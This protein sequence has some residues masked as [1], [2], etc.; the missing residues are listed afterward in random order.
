MKKHLLLFVLTL[1]GAVQAVYAQEPYAVLSDDNT[2]VTFYYDDQKEV[3]GGMDIGGNSSYGSATTA[4]IDASFA[5]YRPTSTAHWFERCSSLTSI[6]GMENLKTDNVTDMSN[7]FTG[8]SGLLSLDVS[9]FNTNKVTSMYGMFYGCRSLTSLDLSGFHTDN[10]TNMYQ[11]FW[12]CSS[13]TSLDV[14]GFNTNKVTSMYGMFCRCSGLS[15]LEVSHFNTDNVTNMSSMFSGCSGL[16]S[17]DVTSF[18]TD[19]V[20]GMS[21]M[22]SDCSGL[23]SLDV[24][25]LNTT[26]V[27][28][29]GYMFNRCLGLTSLDVSH[30]NTANVMDMKGMFS[31]C[32]GLTNLDVS[33]FNTSNVTDMQYMF[34]G[35]S[36]LTSLD[37]TNFNTDNVTNMKYMFLG[38]S[39]LTSL[40]IRSF[41]TANVT[42]MGWMFNSCNNLASIYVGQ[43]WSTAKITGDNYSGTSMFAGDSNL[44]GGAGTTYDPNND[45]YTYAHVD[46]GPDNPGYFT[47]FSSYGITVAGVQVTNVNASAITGDNITGTV[48]FDPSSQILTL[49]GAT[50]NGCIYSYGDLTIDLKGENTITATDTCTIKNTEPTAMH[51]LTFKSTDGTGI[52]TLIPNSYSLYQGFNEP[53]FE[54]YLEVVLGD[55]SGGGTVVIQSIERYDLWIGG[56]QVTERN[57]TDILGDGS[58]DQGKA[59]SFQYV[60]SLNKLFITNT[61]ANLKVETKNPGGLIVYLAPRSANAVSNIVYTGEQQA[62]PLT[63]TTDGNYP[64]AITLSSTSSN[65]YVIMGFSDLVLEQNLV[66]MEPYDN[67]SS[68]T[69]GV[70]LT[71][72]TKDKV[73]VP[74]GSQ[75]VAEGGDSDINKVVD[76]IL[77][78]FGDTEEPDGDGFDDGGFIVINTVTD[79]HQA[80]EAI[81]DYTPGTDDFMEH[82]KGM[83][84]MVPAGNGKIK[85]DVQTMDGHILKVKVGDAYPASFEKTERG[86]VEIPYNIG[87][88]TYVYLYNGGPAAASARGK[89]ISKGGKKKVTH[90][91]VYKTGVSTTKVNS[92]NPVGEASGGAYIGDTSDLEGQEV[93]SD[94]DNIAAMGD[95]DGDG[96]QT[97]ADIVEM[98]KAIMGKHSGVY[99]DTNADINDDGEINI[100][101]IILIVNKIKVE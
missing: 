2:V 70:P 55:I 30:F 95:V 75:I 62:G 27:T 39:S 71:P 20:T 58:A 21:S 79:D 101:D 83:T 42:D 49:N 69:I 60:P 38:C 4:V 18:K 8:C 96:Q 59:A 77:Y 46:G 64:G 86:E 12:L 63:I 3:R 65:D 11:M 89:A 94:E 17:L 24:S 36:N 22:F 53:T 44:K 31:N 14:S 100:S 74:D 84:F 41:N 1:L 40:D 61:D 90:I 87:E 68:I 37:L 35:C 98:V 29:M 43:D 26:N 92:A 81:E 51:N 15:S 85:L 25:N 82:L 50:I 80:A 10:V 78:T 48:S 9:G 19:N 6:T 97:A 93:M 13:L 91:K 16:T 88:P 72:I 28:N 52:L 45:E 99:D 56:I 47:Q 23:T 57:C 32:S 54:D 66:I 5:D 76:D 33:G 7:M 73:I 34:R 67:P